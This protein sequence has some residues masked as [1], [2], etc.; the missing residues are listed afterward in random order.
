MF[1][2]FFPQTASSARIVF[3]KTISWVA[4]YS[5]CIM[6]NTCINRIRSQFMQKTKMGMPISVNRNH[7]RE[8]IRNCSWWKIDYWVARNMSIQWKMLLNS[9][10]WI[11]PKKESENIIIFREEVIL[12]I[13]KTQNEKTGES[14]SFFILKDWSFEYPQPYFSTKNN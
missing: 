8:M 2:Q 14:C 12:K 7:N 11:P 10:K 3:N 5:A 13:F 4:D 6:H 9:K 1:F